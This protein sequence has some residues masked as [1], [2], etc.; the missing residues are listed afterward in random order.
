MKRRLTQFVLVTTLSVTLVA[1]F[2][3]EEL[4]TSKAPHEPSRIK[5]HDIERKVSGALRA[6]SPQAL[7]HLKK[8]KLAGRLNRVL[9]EQ[10]VIDLATAVT[11][12]TMEDRASGGIGL[13]LPRDRLAV[14]A[15]A[16]SVVGDDL[17]RSYA[18]GFE[19]GFDGEV[20]HYRA[21]IKA[22]LKTNTIDGI[23]HLFFA[24]HPTGKLT[25]LVGISETE[26]QVI[27]PR[28]LP[29]H[30]P[31]VSRMAKR[32]DASDS[33]ETIPPGEGYLLEAKDVAKSDA[34][35]QSLDSSTRAL[36][37]QMIE[38][39]TSPWLICEKHIGMFSVDR[40]TARKR[41]KEMW[42]VTPEGK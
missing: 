30:L 31:P 25:V 42:G 41:S 20:K 24:V 38:T 18:Q 7:E 6:E 16:F 34:Y 21:Q 5:D 23:V 28:Q 26:G 35:W 11:S 15:A 39:D 40:D 9:A 32:C 8:S 29:M 4:P 22:A 12:A 17:A 3:A 10:E 37:K 1:V 33:L 19:D 13:A 36:V 2:A 27:A 14:T